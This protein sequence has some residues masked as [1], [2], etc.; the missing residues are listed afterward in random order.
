MISEKIKKKPKFPFIFH[1]KNI[2]LKNKNEN[3]SK[4]KS[5]NCI[6]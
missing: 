1:K 6:F 3:N 5:K 4:L 2:I